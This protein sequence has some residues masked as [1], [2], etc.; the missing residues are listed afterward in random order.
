[1]TD[2][3]G[4][5]RC[6]CY[7]SLRLCVTSERPVA[8]A[9]S[10]SLHSRPPGRHLERLS[11]CPRSLQVAT[12][13]A[14]PASPSST[15]RLPPQSPSRYI[16]VQ[17][18]QEQRPRPV[19]P[20]VSKSLHSP[21][22]SSSTVTTSGCPRS[23][24][25]ATFAGVA[26]PSARLVRL[27]PQSP[28]RYIPRIR[29]H[30]REIRPVAPAVS[31]SLHSAA[32]PHPRGQ[33]SGCPRSLQVATFTSIQLLTAINVRLPPQSPSRYIRGGGA[34]DQRARPVAPA[35]SKSLHSRCRSCSRWKKSGCPR[36][37]QVA[38]FGLREIARQLH[39]RLPPQSPS[40]YIQAERNTLFGLNF[41]PPVEGSMH[42]YKVI[43]L[44]RAYDGFQSPVAGPASGRVSP[45]SHEAIVTISA[46]S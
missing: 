22:C 24:Q 43:R 26:S 18:A 35:V 31:K 5:I 1:M 46:W 10:K 36:S 38:T 19:A 45:E 15:V 30:P 28:S 6:T 7:L 2:S 13:T 17:Q 40:R 33:E 25:V 20:A 9:V 4:H 8:P 12:F 34:A 21:K 3:S 32:G 39:V 23:L 14:S 41:L 37:L 11:G 42:W 16:L 29:A 44:E 27:P